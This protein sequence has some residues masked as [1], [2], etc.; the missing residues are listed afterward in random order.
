MICLFI[1]PEITM[2]K[3]GASVSLH[4]LTALVGLSADFEHGDFGGKYNILHYFTYFYTLFLH[5]NTLKYIKN[6]LE[7]IKTHKNALK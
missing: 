2:F 4:E 3:S 7:Y 1:L 6:I 5:L